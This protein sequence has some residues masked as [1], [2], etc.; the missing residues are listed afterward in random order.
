M[1]GTFGEGRSPFAQNRAGNRRRQRRGDARTG[2]KTCARCPLCRDRPQSA[3]ARLCRPRQNTDPRISWRKA[4]AQALPFEDATFDWCVASSARCSSPTAHPATA[5]LGGCQ[6]GRMFPVQRLGSHRGERVR[7]RCDQC[8]RGVFPERPPR[9]LARTPHGYHDIALIRSDL[10]K[11][12][13]TNV[14][15]ETREEQSRAPS[16]RMPRRLLP[17]TPLRNE[18][19]ARGA[20]R[21]QAA[22][23]HAAAVIAQRHGTS[24]ISAKIQAHVITARP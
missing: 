12:G 20:D 1:P 11:A 18:I 3:D 24:E 22:T 9:F 19:E 7:R 23:D 4:D 21:L 16:A 5:R 2:A 6:A 8:A 14:T 17:G 15:I 13:F 10:A